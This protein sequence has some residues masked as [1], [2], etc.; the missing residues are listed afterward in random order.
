[1]T[2][3]DTELLIGIG[4]RVR[5]SPFFE[6]TVRA[7]VKAFSVYIRMYLPLYYADW[8]TD[9]WSLIYDVSLWDVGVQRQVELRGP[10]AY[11][12]VQ[13]LTP[14]NLS[15]FAIGQGKY[16]LITNDEGGILNDPVL[17]RLADDR[18]W[19]SI[20]DRDI[21]LWV[22]GIAVAEGLDVMVTEP[23]ASP[24][25]LQGPKAGEVMGDLFGDWPAELRYFWFRVAELDGIPLLVAR[26]G[27][28]KQGG[29]ELYL[30]DR[31]CGSILWER[32]IEAGKPY[33]IAPGTPSSIES[34]ESGLLSYG[35]DMD[36]TT[37]PFELGLGKLVD[38]D[39]P[40]D[41]IGKQALQ[42]IQSEGVKRKHVGIEIGGERLPGNEQHW[43]LSVNGETAGVVTSAIFSM[44]L[45]K[46]IALALVPIEHSAAG[47]ALMVQTS[48]G[49]RTATVTTLPNIPPRT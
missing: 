29:F 6:A 26:S 46:N 4:P 39:Q 33:N 10:D 9:Y 13:R 15:N 5:K 18:F 28:S 20:A 40:V 34:I 27:W 1:M 41:F 35:S 21:L 49:E 31:S 25:A 42:R 16:V 3:S 30:L 2:Y 14:R 36:D 48:A 24:L 19:L 17:Q 7:G 43:P 8:E 22:R 47:T 45:E 32:M 12:L 23:D 37:N 11:R 44:R 38:L